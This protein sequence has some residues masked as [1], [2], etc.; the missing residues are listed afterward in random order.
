[1]MM[2]GLFL[3][4]GLVL[5]IGGGDVL[6]RG[7]VRIA[8]RLRLSPMLIGL[9]VVGMGTSMPELA[10]SVQA[11]L[12]GSPGIALGNIVG[13]NI[14]N[15]LLILGAAALI[16]PI[17]VQSKAL[18]RDGGVATLAAMALLAAGASVGLS[19]AAGFAF[20][21]AMA[22][23]IYFAYRQERA[24][25]PHGAAYDRA[26]AMEEVD[27]ALVPHDKPTAS[28]ATA[29][30]L[31]AVGLALIVAG[32][33]VLVDAA[34]QIA[35]QLGISDAVIGLTLVAVGTSFPELVTSVIAAYRRQGD[36]ALG[37]VLGSNIYNI[38]FIGGITGVVAPTAVPA[39]IMG[40]DLWVLL[41]TSVL[42]MVLALT[43]RR[44]GRIEGLTLVAA[45]CVYLGYTVSLA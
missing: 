23:Y 42:V 21:C 13:S 15:A 38:L 30:A 36:I 4:L 14:A 39:S 37:N 16:A 31:F 40:F 44:L 41:A 1:M 28:L 2:Q 32:G 12:A 34:I 8:E 5:L 20:L 11:S 45:Y 22:G 6:V 33:V 19:R 25:A 35:Q 17:A 7:A 9:T 3:L 24:G 18:W 26:I 29:L 43:G 10:A 27:P